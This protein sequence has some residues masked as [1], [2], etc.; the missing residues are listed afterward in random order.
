MQLF[1]FSLIGVVSSLIEYW[2]L[3]PRQPL[4]AF[5]W[6]HG[7]MLSDVLDGVPE[8][9]MALTDGI[10]KLSCGI[11]AVVRGVGTNSRIVHQ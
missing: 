4:Q 6:S 11:L 9:G 10:N 3:I 2:N 7:C 8:A 1:D 5:P